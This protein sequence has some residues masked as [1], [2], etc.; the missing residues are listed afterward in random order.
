MILALAAYA[1]WIRPNPAGARADTFFFWPING[2]LRSYREETFFRLGWY[3][4]HLGLALAVCGLALL[5]VRLRRPWQK[6]F[7]WVGLTA[8]FILCYDLRNNPLQPY[9][10][11]RL[12]PA[13]LPCLILG[14]AAFLPICSEV[15]LRS[16][17]RAGW[18]SIGQKLIAGVA[19]LGTGV[20]LFGFLRVNADLN[21]EPEK[22]NFAGLVAQTSGLAR[23]LPARS[24]LLI[25][26]N[27]PL[28]ALATPLQIIDGVDA[29]LI[30]PASHSQAYQDEFLRA[31][32]KWTREGHP[33]MSLSPI[34]DDRL[35][36]FGA[37]LAPTLHGKFS[38]PM[39]QQSP[40]R[41]NANPSHVEWDYFLAEI[42]FPNLEM[43][44]RKGEK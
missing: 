29:I 5:A 9:A 31:W 38:F 35:D 2:F 11:R 10:M 33:V 34:A 7:F 3:W 12:I 18:N 28:A 26:S 19:S 17:Q 39:V 14:A 36:L 30:R 37:Q 21:T 43:P 20:L 40:V 15:L 8:L 32:R 24:I 23:Q 42:R 22:G 16:N 41:L 4:Q 25:R 27:A 44:N 13:A 1:Y 6:A